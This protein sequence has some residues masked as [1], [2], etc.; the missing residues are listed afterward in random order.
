MPNPEEMFLCGF[1]PGLGTQWF[2]VEGQPSGDTR[3]STISKLLSKCQALWEALHD[4][5][6]SQTQEADHSSILI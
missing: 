5:L 4:R 2:K 6:P 1:L 3:E